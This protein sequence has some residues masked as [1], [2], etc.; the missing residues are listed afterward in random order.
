MAREVH[1]EAAV[2]TV[3]DHLLAALIDVGQGANWQRAGGKAKRP[4]P[5]PRPTVAKQDRKVL[6]GEELAKKLKA[7]EVRARE[8]KRRAVTD[9]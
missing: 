9:G 4:D 8:R 2:W 3:T 1:G 5:F 7:L 6:E